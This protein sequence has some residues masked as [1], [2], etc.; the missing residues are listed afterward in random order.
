MLSDIKEVS[1][2]VVYAGGKE[3]KFKTLQELA[4]VTRK[5]D[6]SA[7]EFI[8]VFSLFLSCFLLHIPKSYLIS[9]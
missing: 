5:E 6:N 1:G 9:K 7:P 2:K 4:E 8:Y 3:I